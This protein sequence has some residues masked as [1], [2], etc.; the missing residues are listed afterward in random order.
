V[1]AIDRGVAVFGNQGE[2]GVDRKLRKCGFACGPELIEVSGVLLGGLDGL[3]LEGGGGEAPIG[4]AVEFDC[5]DA[6]QEAGFVHGAGVD[7]DA[8][9]SKGGS[10]VDFWRHHLG[11][12]FVGDLEADYRLSVLDGNDSEADRLPGFIAPIGMIGRDSN[13]N[14]ADTAL[15][16][17][18]ERK[19]GEQ[20][21]LEHEMNLYDI[22]RWG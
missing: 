10:L 17:E 20:N 18:R 22:A 12:D 19:E 3:G 8:F 7:S 15:R 16:D 6:T 14:C 21:E 11:T 1:E 2:S 5:S 4:L 13:L 9:P